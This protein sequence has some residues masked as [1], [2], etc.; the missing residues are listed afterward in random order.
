MLQSDQDPLFSLDRRQSEAAAAIQRGVCR[1]LRAL[2]HSVVCELP[3]ANGRRADVVGL[4]PS[5]DVVIVEIKSCLIDFR[6]DG[7]WHDYLDY[8]DRLY[9]AVDA[10]F[11]C[12]VLPEDAGLILAD[13][14]GAELMREP[15][16]ERLNAARRKAMMLCFARA[17][18]LRLQHH[19][20]PG[21][22]FES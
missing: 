9:F 2:G 14:Y 7:K 15:V 11:P 16:E 21:C 18:A 3:L 19:L 6:T 12:Y 22:G 8:C 10:D 20:D 13:R 1:S 5:G 4:S 17:A